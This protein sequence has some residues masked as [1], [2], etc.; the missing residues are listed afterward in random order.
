VS[1]K[2]NETGASPN[3][4]F[5]VPVPSAA[6]TSVL[7]IDTETVGVTVSTVKVAVLPPMPALPSASW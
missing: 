3:V 5:T 7:S 1:A 2:V 4:N 6:F